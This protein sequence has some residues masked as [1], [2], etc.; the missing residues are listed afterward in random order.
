MIGLF[1]KTILRTIPRFCFATQPSP[2]TTAPAYLTADKIKEALGE[3][4]YN[5][6]VEI[7][8]SK[9]QIE[10]KLHN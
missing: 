6:L 1:Q 3:E 5:R 10:L 7:V 8:K 2:Y 9:E 4:E